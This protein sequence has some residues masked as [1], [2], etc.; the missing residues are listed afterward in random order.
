MTLAPNTRRLSRLREVVVS[1]VGTDFRFAQRSKGLGADPASIGMLG[2]KRQNV[3]DEF[4]RP[5]LVAAIK[6]RLGSCH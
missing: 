2:F 4:H 1:P 6:R 3:T 5:L